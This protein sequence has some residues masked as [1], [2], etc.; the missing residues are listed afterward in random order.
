MTQHTCHMVGNA[1]ALAGDCG[2][3][4]DD[5]VMLDEPGAVVLALVGV[6]LVIVLTACLSLE[7]RR[8]G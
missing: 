7:G 1:I 2:P 8:A 3:L 6:L 5:V 4:P